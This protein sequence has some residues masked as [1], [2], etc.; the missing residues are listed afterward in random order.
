MDPVVKKLFRQSMNKSVQWNACLENKCQ[1]DMKAFMKLHKDYLHKVQLNAKKAE[2][3]RMTENAFESWYVKATN[4]YMFSQTR[5]KLNT[6]AHARCKQATRAYM[7]ALVDLTEHD[8]TKEM[9]ILAKEARKILAKNAFSLEDFRR[10]WVIV[11]T[12]SD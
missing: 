7:K 8:C 2:K 11:N 4:D 12:S 6:C 5:M 1:E 10:L 9:C 3:K